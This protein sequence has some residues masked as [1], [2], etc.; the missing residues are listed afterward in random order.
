MDNS[1]ADALNDAL[2]AALLEPGPPAVEAANAVHEYTCTC[3]RNGRYWRQVVR[4]W[5]LA[6]MDYAAGTSAV[7]PGPAPPRYPP[8]DWQPLDLT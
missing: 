4:P 3:V 6:M 7:S 8:D 5:L 2:F 1:H